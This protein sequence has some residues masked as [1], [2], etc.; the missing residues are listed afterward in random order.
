[1]RVAFGHV[2]RKLIA[3]LDGE[4]PRDLSDRVAGH[5]QR[6]PRCRREAEALQHGRD[7]LRA[8]PRNKAPAS[9]WTRIEAHIAL[10]PSTSPAPA[11]EQGRPRHSRWAVAAA[12]MVL[13]AGV[14]IW[15]LLRPTPW[16]ATP[17]FGIPLL[18]AAP[19]RQTDE[20]GIGQWLVTD[21]MSRVDVRIEGLGR[22]EVAPETRVMRLT[23][24]G[25]RQRLSL[26]S[27]AIT[28]RIAA[29]PGLFVVETPAGRVVDLGCAYTLAV[30]AAGHL[31][32]RVDLGRVAIVG[33]GRRSIIGAGYRCRGRAGLGPG[34]PVAASASAALDAALARFDD[35]TGNVDALRAVLRAAGPGDSV[36]LWHLLARAPL[37]NRRE[38]LDPL[39]AR[40]PPPAGVTRLD[41][42]RLD[43]GALDRWLIEIERRPGPLSVP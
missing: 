34:T 4:L 33:Y 8:L 38:I 36:T 23:A 43:P 14:G 3:Y 31:S 28:A 7:S 17:R 37:A 6:C 15:R 26:A 39:T 35:A 18:G 16:R 5:L 29:A 21:R 41:L 19:L 24:R 22:V 12:T 32:L 13:L 10:P 30:D 27:G 42:L 25:G 2:T 20:F 9:L 1:M 11:V 40:V